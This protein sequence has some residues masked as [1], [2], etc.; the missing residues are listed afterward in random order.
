M[1]IIDCRYTPPF[2]L[3]NG[4]V[5]SILPTLVRRIDCSHFQRERVLTDDGDF[6]DLDWSYASAPTN[7]S[8]SEKQRS[9]K[10]L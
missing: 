9:N 7:A 4:Y 5:Q 1:P 10:A 2:L 8:A 3:S 6:L